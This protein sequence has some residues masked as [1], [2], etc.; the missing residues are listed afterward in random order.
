MY[1]HQPGKCGNSQQ[2]L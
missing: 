2:L 1:F